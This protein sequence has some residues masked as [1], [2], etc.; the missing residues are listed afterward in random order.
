MMSSGSR[1]LR[2]DVSWARG[3]RGEKFSAET[4]T[5]GGYRRITGGQLEKKL[6]ESHKHFKLMEL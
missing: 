3:G 4:T 5:E 1:V 2:S 6:Q